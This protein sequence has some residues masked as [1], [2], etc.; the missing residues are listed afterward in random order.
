MKIAI[1]GTIGSGKS[2]VSSLIREKGYEV[3]DCDAYNAWLLEKGNE[4]W[5]RVREAFPEAFEED[6]LDKKKLASIIFTD[7]EKKEVLEFLL[8]PLIIGEM[9]KEAEERDPFFAEVPLLFENGLERI[10][11]RSLLIVCDENIALERLLN[12]GLDSNEALRRIANQM[13]VE[14]KIL[15]ADEII[16]NNGNFAE[17]KEKTEKWLKNYVR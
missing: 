6:E 5:K 10:F 1:T 3:F 17:L 8:H 7:R 9:L 16:Y 14:K 12:R 2:T 11:D 15:R 13:S 4:G